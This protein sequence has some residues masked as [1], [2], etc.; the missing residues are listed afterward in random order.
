MILSSLDVKY[1]SIEHNARRIHSDRQTA[2]NTL[3]A[4]LLEQIGQPTFVSIDK[5][6]NGFYI[7]LRGISNTNLIRAFLADKDLVLYEN[8]TED[9]CIIYKP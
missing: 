4:L 9:Y 7:L 6:D 8:K 5:K 2:L 3:K 1:Q